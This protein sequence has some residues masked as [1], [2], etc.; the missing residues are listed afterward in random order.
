MLKNTQTYLAYHLQAILHSL[1]V[2][3]RK[4]LATV[5]TLIVIAI[6][7][8]LPA[9]FW[10]FTDNISQLSVG[11]ERGGSISLY[12]KHTQTEAE[13]VQLLK[14]VRGMQGVGQAEL[15]SSEAGLAELTQQEGMRDIMRYLPE[16][17]LP[18]VIEISPSLVIDSPSK[19]DE[20]VR[21]LQA[22]PQVE[23][24]KLD[25]E[26][27]SR[28]HAISECMAQVTKALMVL[29]ALAVVLIIGTTLGLA[30]RSRQEEIQILK[31]IGAADPFIR[32]PFLYSG[33]WY[34]MA[35]AL[36]AVFLVNILILGLGSAL[37]QLTLTYQMH[38]ALVGLSLKQIPLLVLFAMILGW[39]GALVS[40]SRQL[41]SIEPYT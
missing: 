11:W 25:R 17:P 35:G 1:N 29:L 34:G 12:L 22:L 14:K 32:R 8:A 15:K 18:S 33:M 38:Y 27:I 39:L 41:A 37:N 3:C 21:Q 4:P 20:L 23:Q 7:L 2:M 30:I 26:W 40:V 19:L 28:L 13:Q 16:N 5:M 31:L 24:V 10:V 36:V 9:F 6:A